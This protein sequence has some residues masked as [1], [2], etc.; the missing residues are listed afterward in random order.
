MWD[1]GR[2]W[3]KIGGLLN[4]MCCCSMWSECLHLLMN[5]Q[6][7]LKKIEKKNLYHC[8]WILF[9][10]VNVHV[11]KSLQNFPLL[12]NIILSISHQLSI[13]IPEYYF[14]FILKLKFPSIKSCTWQCSSFSNVDVFQ[15]YNDK[16]ICIYISTTRNGT[17]QYSTKTVKFVLKNLLIFYTFQFRREWG[18][19][20]GGGRGDGG[21]EA[22][23]VEECAE[24]GGQVSKLLLVQTPIRLVSILHSVHQTCSSTYLIQFI[25]QLF[26]HNKQ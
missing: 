4:V 2:G 20:C 13:C 23:L 19:T 9:K 25:Y 11:A 3:W 6:C 8:E 1:S 14:L 17:I 18:L 15:P 16:Y 7:W 24:G 21:Y 10:Y 12:S 22:W 26:A 5:N